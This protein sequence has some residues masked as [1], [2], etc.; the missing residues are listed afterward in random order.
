MHVTDWAPTLLQAAGVDSAT[1]DSYGF[2]GMSQYDTIFNAGAP[3]R[4]EVVKSHISVK[5]IIYYF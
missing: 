4:E 5:L 3:V 2:D 1:I